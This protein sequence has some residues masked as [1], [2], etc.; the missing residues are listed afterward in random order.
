MTKLFLDSNVVIYS[1]DPRDRSKQDR[2]LQWLSRAAA[3][4]SISAEVC[5]ESPSAAVRKLGLKPRFARDAIERL[6]PWCTA[7]MTADEVRRA[8]ELVEARR[9]S[10]WGALIFASAIGAGY[11]HL[12]TE[13]G[14]SAPVVDGVRIIDPF[15]VAPEEVL[16]A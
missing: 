9:M 5:A 1:L 13:D 12:V 7:P 4:S 10:W 3:R 8:L 6:L 16:G 11:T 2:C 15:A 14:Q